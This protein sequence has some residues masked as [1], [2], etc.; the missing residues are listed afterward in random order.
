MWN[1]VLDKNDLQCFMNEIGCFHDSCIKEMRYLSGAYVDDDLAMHP[2][3]DKRI[4]NV[5][6]QHQFEDLSMIEMQFVGLKCLKLFPINEEYTCEILDS[7]MLLKDDC[8]CWCDCGDIS[9]NDFAD[10]EGTFVCALK[11]RWR[12]IENRMGQDDFYVDEK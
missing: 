8:I 11:L 10:Y 2:V 9:E 4:L 6:I 7:T 12:S 5:I 1:E 3:N